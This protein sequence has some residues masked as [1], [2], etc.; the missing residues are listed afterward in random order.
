[1]EKLNTKH[2]TYEGVL[3][4]DME[5]KGLPTE[6]ELH[7]K[8]GAQVM[9]VNNDTNGQWVN[10]TIGKVTQIDSDEIWVKIHNGTEVCVTEHQWDMYKYFFDTKNN[11]LS[12]ESA[13]YFT[14]IPVKLAWAIT[15]HKSQG[16][17]FDNVIID[18]ER[19]SFAHGQTYVALSRCTTFEGIVLKKPIKASDIR[20]DWRV[21]KFITDYQYDISEQACSLKQKVQM[22]EDAIQRKTEL[23]IVY[24]KTKDVKSKRKIRPEF[25]G[26]CSYSGKK[27]LGL[28][29]W[30]LKRNDTRVFRVDR[31]LEMKVL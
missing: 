19:G 13:G 2:H 9:F 25:V 11:I 3:K 18:L 10:G 16:K 29:A 21:Q 22:I 20:L 17:T 12:Q 4:G 14:Q 24:L 27:F 26:E 7:L 8:I 23:E 30:C 15:I 6:K 28:Q 31:I 5:M 1:M